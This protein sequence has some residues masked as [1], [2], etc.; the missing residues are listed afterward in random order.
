MKV[1]K[2]Y[3]REIFLDLVSKLASLGSVLDEHLRCATVSENT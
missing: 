1:K 2:S 3:N